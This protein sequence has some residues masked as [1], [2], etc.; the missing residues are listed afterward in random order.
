MDN[1]VETFRNAKPV[2][3]NQKVLIPGDIEREMTE[4]RMMN[5]IPLLQAVVDDLQGLG[6]RFGVTF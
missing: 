6:D 3:E 2:D 5:G 1:W 4:D